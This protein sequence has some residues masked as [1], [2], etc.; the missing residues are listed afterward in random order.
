[1]IRTLSLALALSLAL[2]ACSPT[3]GET[4][5][6]PA[7]SQLKDTSSLPDPFETHF[8]WDTTR[9]DIVTTETGLQYIRVHSG[10]AAGS[11]PGLNDS[12]T[13]HYDGRLAENGEKFDASYDRG[14]PA[15]FG[16]TQVIPG[17]TEV[18][19]LMVPGDDWMVYL[20][21]DLA[22]GE[23]GTPGGPI[24]PNADLVFRVNLIETIADTTPGA[25][26]FRANLPWDAAADEVTTTASGLQY[27]ILASGDA[28]GAS[29]GPDS[30]VE[31]HV[32][33]READD[34]RRIQSTW[35]EGRTQTLP[36]GRLFP[37]WAEATQLMH[38]GDDWLI[39]LPAGPLGVEEDI[40]MRVNLLAV[41]IPQI[42]DSAAWET[43][44]PWNTESADVSKTASGLEYIVLEAGNADGP[45][46]TRSDTVEVYYE[47]RLASDGAVFDSAYARGESIEFGVTQVIPGWTEALQL[48]HP[49]DRWLVYLPSEIA[50]G[51]TPRPGGVI[52]PGDD[53]I[54]EM[55]L[56]GIR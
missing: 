42:S 36:V 47:G 6:I 19:Q 41:K 16:V 15:T 33:V 3:E 52:K 8:P 30:K 26:I 10:D 18:L 28:D 40:I 2:T 7:T 38:P 54:F 56:V 49:G 4:D 43:H 21:S 25:E 13:V 53:L 24:G 34:G 27:K 51:Q 12:V 44:T 32:E 5:T 45:T 48:M 20:P 46:P 50:Y 1:M 11:K 14:D 31:M 9:D 55:Q 37:G 35:A 29:P 22:Y 23:R 17:W 39:F